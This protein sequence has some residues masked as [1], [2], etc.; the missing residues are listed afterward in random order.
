MD[1]FTIGFLA[2]VI[3]Y[4]IL[5]YLYGFYMFRNSIY[6]VLYSGFTE[7]RMRRKSIEGMS[8]SYVLKKQFGINRIIYHILAKKSSVPSAFVTIF[9]TS[10]CYIINMLKGHENEN[11]SVDAEKFKQNYI[12]N[13]INESVY[14]SMTI[15][16]TMM[17]VLPDH[18][19]MAPKLVGKKDKLTIR[20]KELIDTLIGIH[21]KSEK[22]ITSKDV[23]GI[24]MVL[25]HDS[26]ESEK[27]DSN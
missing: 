1:I 2:V 27:N 20:R 13:Q 26:I 21:E 17:T 19:D 4:M 15:P 6:K 7:Y 18:Y 10:G 12:M 25:A 22:I 8:E 14:K 23:Y 16:M 5:K 9:L 24:F 3:L 11:L